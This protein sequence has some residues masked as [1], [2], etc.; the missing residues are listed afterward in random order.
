M[1]ET[2]EFA[3]GGWLHDAR[4]SARGG[5][6]NLPTCAHLYIYIYTR[7]TSIPTLFFIPLSS[8]VLLLAA[9]AAAASGGG[10]CGGD[11]G[12]GGGDVDGGSG[13][14]GDAG[15]CAFFRECSPSA[16]SD[17]RHIT[18][19]QNVHPSNFISATEVV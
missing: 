12:D 5:R 6:L 3:K 10:I 16:L 11:G 15:G 4:G 13:G 17:D 19:A 14:S 9:A 18:L 1:R 7:L 8:G 2:K